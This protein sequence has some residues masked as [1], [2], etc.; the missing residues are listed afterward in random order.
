MPATVKAG[1]IVAR[2]A[3]GVW[4]CDD[5]STL[6]LLN[7]PQFND[8]PTDMSVWRDRDLAYATRAAEWMLGEIVEHTPDLSGGLDDDRLL[9]TPSPADLAMDAMLEKLARKRGRGRG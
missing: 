1:S 6:E 2:I 4:T 5:P 8:L 3:N 9:A 7:S